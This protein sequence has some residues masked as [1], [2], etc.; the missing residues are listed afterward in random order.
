MT[1]DHGSQTILVKTPISISLTFHKGH[2]LI[3]EVTQGPLC[4]GV[5]VA[6]SHLG[7]RVLPLQWE[8]SFSISSPPA[9]LC[10]TVTLST[11]SWD[12]CILTRAVTSVCSRQSDTAFKC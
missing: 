12:N 9:W 2:R 11:S 7:Y 6:C 10:R 3:L 1:P 4:S 8:L 5:P